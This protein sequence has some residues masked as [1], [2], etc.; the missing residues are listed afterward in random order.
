M[1]CSDA[2]QE[3]HD[4]DFVIEGKAS[5]VLLEKVEQLFGKGLRVVQQWKTGNFGAF[6]PFYLFAS[7]GRGQTSR[8]TS[9]SD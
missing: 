1:R 3:L 9:R 4:E 7:V 2:S 5:V 8:K 6:P